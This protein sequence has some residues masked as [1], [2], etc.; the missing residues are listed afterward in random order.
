MMA[1]MKGMLTWAC[2]AIPVASGI[3]A[4]MVPTEVPM[5]IEMKQAEKKRPA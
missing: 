5:A 2:W 4:T 1:A 3:R